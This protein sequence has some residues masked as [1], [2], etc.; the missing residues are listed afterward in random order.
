MDFGQ[1][2]ESK[3]NI[4]NIFVDAPA[5]NA[6]ILPGSTGTIGAALSNITEIKDFPVRQ[7]DQADHIFSIHF[8]L[9]YIAC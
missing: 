6:I 2:L 9:N 8:G 1:T 4:T 3:A 7:F 5:M